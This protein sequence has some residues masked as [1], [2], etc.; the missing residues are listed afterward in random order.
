[1]QYFQIHADQLVFEQRPTEWAVSALFGKEINAMRTDRRCPRF[2][3]M[4][5]ST[6]R[7]TR[8]HQKLVQT[9]K[10]FSHKAQLHPMYWL[11]PIAVKIKT[12]FIISHF[13]YKTVL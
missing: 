10:T 5:H 7:Q 13:I 4:I 8:K 3:Q 6:V 2:H 1:M 9:T 12:H 11:Y